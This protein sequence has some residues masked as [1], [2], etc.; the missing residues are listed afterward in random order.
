MKGT[1]SLG[2]GRARPPVDGTA[3]LQPRDGY[4]DRGGEKVRGLGLAKAF[5]QTSS[6]S[7]CVSRVLWNALRV[8]SLQLRMIPA[9]DEQRRALTWPRAAPNRSVKSR[10][11]AVFRL[12]TSSSVVGGSNGEVGGV[13][14][15]KDLVRV[16]R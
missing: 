9:N 11:F 10:A 16:G 12:M 2:S 13:R 7:K 4:G 1:P 3:P 14:A 15:L 8:R 6:G 5:D